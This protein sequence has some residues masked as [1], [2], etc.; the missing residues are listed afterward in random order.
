MRQ[1][2]Y[3]VAISLDG[4]IATEDGGYVW[5]PEDPEVDAAL[6]EMVQRYDALL[7]GR[8]T[9]EVVQGALPF[10]G[11]EYYVVS[12][13]LDPAEH[14]DVTI[15]SRD[16]V[17]RVSALKQEDGKDIWLFGGG[18]LF[19]AMLEAGLVDALEI[20]LI[21]RVLGAGIPMLAGLDGVA[22][23]R[24]TATR[25]FETSGIRLIEYEVGRVVG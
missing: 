12:T 7:M 25:S 24:P 19:R 14:S 15:I 10:E 4:F 2:R 18:V 21:P 22:E 17:E 8:G 6:G 5:I 20:G 9:Y 16:V 23:L 3:G 11:M 1:L 13:T